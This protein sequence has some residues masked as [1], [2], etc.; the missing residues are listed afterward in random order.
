MPSIK[1]H[2]EN[3]GFFQEHQ[4]QIIV[5]Q[6]FKGLVVLKKNGMFHGRINTNNIFFESQNNKVMI[7]DYGIYN[8]L[9]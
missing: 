5:Q 7:S 2:I 3:Y 9:N 8:V 4:I 1:E 6:V